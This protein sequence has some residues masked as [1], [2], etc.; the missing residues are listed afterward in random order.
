MKIKSALH[1]MC[2]GS[3]RPTCIDFRHD[4]GDLRWSLAIAEVLES[5]LGNVCAKTCKVSPVGLSEYVEVLAYHEVVTKSTS[6]SRP[7]RQL[8]FLPD[9]NLFLEFT[10]GTI[11][12]AMAFLIMSF[13][14]V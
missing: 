12:L 3:M 9:S 10:K 6:M 1:L 5:T 4:G 14:T 8:I 2:Q 11:K 13:M 7:S